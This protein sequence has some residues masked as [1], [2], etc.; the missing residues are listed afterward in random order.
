MLPSPTQ[1]SNLLNM[2]MY[3][4]KV[5]IFRQIS[6]VDEQ[7]ADDY[8]V[9]EIYT[10]IPCKLSQD[11]KSFVSA[12]TD[13]QIDI[14]IELKLF[15]DSKYE[16]LPNDILKVLHNGQEFLLNAIKSFKYQSHQ[17]VT[18]KRKDEAR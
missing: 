3:Q 8:I 18:V 16:I 14:A 1:L 7:G 13:R 10:D 11:N 17:E 12:A 6:A 4:D 9:Q 15:V 2:Y 5:S